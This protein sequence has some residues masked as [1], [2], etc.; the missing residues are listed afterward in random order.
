[1]TE[2]DFAVLADRIR[3][4]PGFCWASLVLEAE[5]ADDGSPIG[6]EAPIPPA[7]LDAGCEGQ[8]TQSAPQP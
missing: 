7:S 8:V 4:D 6:D 5:E 3:R 2:E 1:M